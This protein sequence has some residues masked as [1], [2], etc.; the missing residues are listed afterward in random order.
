MPSDEERRQAAER[1][2]RSRRGEQLNN[3]EDDQNE[4]DDLR[5]RF[6]DPDTD[7]RLRVPSGAALPDVP[8]VE[9]SRPTLPGPDPSKPASPLLGPIKGDLRS[10]GEASTI[11][12]TLVVSIAIGAGLGYL[13]DQFVLG[14]PATPWGLIAGFLLGVASGFVNLIRVTNRLNERQDRDDA[15]QRRRE[16]GGNK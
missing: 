4:K 10:M 2:L 5:A 14:R 16:N 11:G 1:L 12:L 6:P 13:V 15:R 7:E 9:F 3:D 8:K